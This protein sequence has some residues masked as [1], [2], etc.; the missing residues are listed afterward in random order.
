[1][2]QIGITSR[3][4]ALPL[5]FAEKRG[6]FEEFGLEAKLNVCTHFKGVLALL[7]DGRLDAGEIPTLA[8]I[9]ERFQNR[10]KSKRLFKGLN[11]YHSPISFYSRFLFRKEDIIKN[12]NYF[13]PCPYFYSFERLYTEKFL[14]QY[15][16]EDSILCRFQ[17]TSH[18]LKERDF[19]KPNCLGIASDFFISPF[20]RKFSDFRSELEMPIFKEIQSIPST[21]LVVSGEALQKFSKDI[22]KLLKS[23]KKSMETLPADGALGGDFS[24]S[25]TQ[26]KLQSIFRT[27][28]EIREVLYLTNNVYFPIV[29]KVIS[30]EEITKILD[31]SEIL[32]RLESGEDW[33]P[34]DLK[35]FRELEIP[36]TKPSRIINYRKLN[37]TRHLITDISSIALDTLQGNF[38][39]R[40][41]IEENLRLDNRVKSLINLMLDSFG[42]FIDKQKEQ[43]AT[44]ENL[45]SLLEIKLDR[46]AVDLQYSE[47][48]YRYLFEFSNDAIAIVDADNSKIIEGNRQFRTLT[49]YNRV[50][51]AR[52]RIDELLVISPVSPAIHFGKDLSKESMLSV[53][54][55]EIFLKDGSRLGVDLSFASILLSPKKRFQVTI[56]PNQER[57]EQERLQHEFISNISHELRS[58]MTN[59]RGY[60]EILRSENQ[61]DQETQDSL[62]VI[63]K[64]AKRLSFLIENLLKL[65]TSL[66]KEEESWEEFDPSPIIEDVIQLN[67]HLNKDKKILTE[68]QLE[69]G[70]KLVGMR[71]EFSQ[72][73]TNLYVN[74]LKYTNKGKVEVIWTKINDREGE[75]VVRD[76]GIGIDPVYKDRIFERFFRIPSS[77]NKKIGGTGLGLSI[78]K[79][80]VEKMEGR[81][82]VQSELRKGSIFRVLFPLQTKSQASVS[83]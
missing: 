73:V 1:M 63:D 45:I 10:S 41:N 65:T 8:Y 33:Q 57:K 24:V 11:L 2:L 67:S 58:P 31:F 27:K 43:I 32:E 4:S 37:A 79:S 53:T 3:P 44:L 68:V 19:L 34:S 16:L 46:S 74:A 61:F 30:Q 28:G 76:S 15:L 71:F 82:Y 77:D 5:L 35:S 40:L 83:L 50:D 36:G 54:N 72:I 52:K 47:E 70:L 62:E 13:V 21:I 59:I 23:V 48:K 66:E 20:L 18:F 80:L 81:L 69:K 22:P 64:N 56:R 29:Q 25:S 78:V 38:S 51:L 49:G 14:D 7:E 42:A 39:S 17:D 75:L 60:L 9:L 55:A 6:I 12:R 26:E